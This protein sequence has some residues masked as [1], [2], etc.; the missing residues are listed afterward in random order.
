[1]PN[2]KEILKNMKAV[3]FF[4]KGVSKFL[5]VSE[6]TEQLSRRAVYKAELKSQN[7]H[8]YKRLEKATIPVGL[9]MF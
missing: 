1:M 9:T 7:P 2:K 5:T 6:Y 4:S 8:T 3:K